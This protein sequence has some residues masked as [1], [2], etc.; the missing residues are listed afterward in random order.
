M[1]GR[2]TIVFFPEAAFGPAL[3]SVAIAQICR[4]LGGAIERLLTET[5]MH[6]R[7]AATS[8][9]MRAADGRRKAARLLDGLLER[10]G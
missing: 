6:E 1:V 8:A 7:L 9:H 4:E 2:K 10:H 5:A 3:N